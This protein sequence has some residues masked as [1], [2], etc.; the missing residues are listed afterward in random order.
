M[1]SA[2]TKS[3][4]YP[5]QA[6]PANLGRQRGLIGVGEA[7]NTME[8]KQ[9]RISTC[10]QLRVT[11]GTEG[12]WGLNNPCFR[13]NQLDDEKQWFKMPTVGEVGY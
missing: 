10:K 9:T 4:N 7:R 2:K 8:R 13:Q 5:S 11:W 12:M 6:T 3:N 1:D